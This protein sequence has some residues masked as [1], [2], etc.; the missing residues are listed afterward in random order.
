M[1]NLRIKSKNKTFE[2]K[3]EIAYRIKNLRNPNV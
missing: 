3:K 2:N 1:K